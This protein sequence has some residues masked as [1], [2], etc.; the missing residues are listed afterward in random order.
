MAT[1]QCPNPSGEKYTVNTLSRKLRSDTEFAAF[2]SAQ[3]KLAQAGDKEAMACIDSYYQPSDA[4]MESC[5]V[6]PSEWSVMRKCT[7]SGSLLEI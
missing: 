4:E 6:P 2:F 1:Y 3:M 7:E 5:G